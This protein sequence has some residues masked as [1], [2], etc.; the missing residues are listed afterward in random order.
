MYTDI[1]SKIFRMQ[2]GFN[3]IEKKLRYVNACVRISQM[4]CLS[5]LAIQPP[6]L[7]YNYGKFKSEYLSWRIKTFMSHHR[8]LPS[9]NYA[10][11][12]ENT[13]FI[14]K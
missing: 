12:K 1:N 13:I 9:K 5:L 7:E 14:S 11:C 2:V 4:S 8:I 6:I 3:D 10:I